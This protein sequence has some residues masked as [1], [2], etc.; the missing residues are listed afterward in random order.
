MK[1]WSI[2]DQWRKDELCDVLTWRECCMND[3]LIL[4]CQNLHQSRQFHHTSWTDLW[5]CEPQTYSYDKTWKSSTKKSEIHKLL[6]QI[7]RSDRWTR[8]K[9]VDQSY[10]IIIK[11]LW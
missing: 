10:Y 11:D 6:F 9:W 8:L 1:S 2:S 4:L 5:W 3:E 7:F